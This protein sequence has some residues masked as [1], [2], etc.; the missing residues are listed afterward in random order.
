MQKQSHIS[1]FISVKN[2]CPHGG[3]VRA[4]KIKNSGAQFFC[5]RF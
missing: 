2:T 5:V 4:E 3:N 1:V